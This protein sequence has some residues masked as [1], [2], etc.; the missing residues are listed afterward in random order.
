[1]RSLPHDWAGFRWESSYAQL[2]A[3]LHRRENPTPVRAPTHLT[4]NEPLAQKLALDT[5]ALGSE[6]GAALLV[7][8]LTIDGI[9]PLAQAYAGHQFGHFTIL[10]D[11]RAILL[12]EHR[13]P[14][15]QLVDVQ[16]KGPGRTYFSRGGD[17]RLGLG[18]ALREF[19]IS[20]AMAALGIPTTR[21]LAVTTTGEEV[22]RDG[23][24]P[25][26]V[27]T[28]IAASHVRVGTFQFA[29]VT[30]DEAALKGLVE[31]CIA[32]HY[33]ELGPAEPSLSPGRVG[34]FFER[35]V[36]RQ[37]ELVAR[38]LSVGFIHG[39]MNTD[40]TTI[41]GETI[42]FGP[43]AFLDQYDPSKVF[44]S[45][46]RGGRYAFGQ[47]PGIAGWNL[48]RLGDTLIPFLGATPAEGEA[49]ANTLVQ[50]FAEKFSTH[51][52]KVFGTKLGFAEP[53]AEVA[54][55]LQDLLDI[56]EREHLDFHQMWRDLTDTGPQSE[57]PLPAL[58]EWTKRWAERLHSEGT[59]AA[60]AIA[61]MQ[62]ANPI[63]IPRNHRVEDAL[64]RAYKG[65]LAPFNR[66]LAAVRTPFL[67]SPEKRELGAP[68][69]KPNPNYR[70]YCGT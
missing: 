57:A 42:D 29:T 35:V 8:N 56:A 31:F 55:L 52:T 65:D 33:P 27:L 23:F 48:A 6:D 28:R 20:E 59:S 21:S 50:T 30:Q 68:P 4:L 17:G 39:V 49:V 32:R 67:D 14:S 9:V 13:T 69:V 53:Q 61:R 58:T 62:R 44:S 12:G 63:V 1:M 11:G 46:D 64:E 60:D 36:D 22:F 5:T 45:I 7:G 43:C 37:A 70:T 41:S 15:G 47:Q 24:L 66:L 16:W 38:W 2:P 10:G 3:V 54:A 25:G 26:A 40:N 18:P 19:L 34:R 51:L